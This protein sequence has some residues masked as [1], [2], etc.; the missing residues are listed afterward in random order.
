MIG[1]PPAF[2]YHT[3]HSA[4][5]VPNGGVGTLLAVADRYRAAYLVIDPN[6]PEP[7]AELYEDM[8]TVGLAPVA[9]FDGG[10]VQLYRLAGTP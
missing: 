3:G 7:L 2:W 8:E 10:R 1:N 9:T 6:R 4:L 5:V